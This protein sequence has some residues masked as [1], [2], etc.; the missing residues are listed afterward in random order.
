MLTPVFDVVFDVIVPMLDPLDLCKLRSVNRHMAKSIAYENKRVEE[1]MA[2]FERLVVVSDN[3]F[4]IHSRSGKKVIEL[5]LRERVDG[6]TSLRM[7]Y[8]GRPYHGWAVPLMRT[9]DGKRD[10]LIR[11]VFHNKSTYLLNA[12]AVFIQGFQELRFRQLIMIDL[13]ISKNET[14]SQTFYLNFVPRGWSY[15][16]ATA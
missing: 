6:P 10:N 4:R 5:I 12:E 16:P 9:I 13:L 8:E 11:H 1:A 14:D 15:T 2:K 7:Q 3:T